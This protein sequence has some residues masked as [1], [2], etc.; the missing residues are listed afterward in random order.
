MQKVITIMIVQTRVHV[1]H[2]TEKEI[3]TAL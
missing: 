2:G 1:R 3:L